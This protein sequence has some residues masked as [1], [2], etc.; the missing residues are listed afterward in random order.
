MSAEA[1]LQGGRAFQQV[2]VVGRAS[3][4][5]SQKGRTMASRVFVCTGD[6]GSLP[7]ASSA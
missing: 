3:A 4:S 6:D 5:N 1:A 7:A 2:K